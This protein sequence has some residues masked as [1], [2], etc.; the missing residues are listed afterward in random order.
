VVSGLALLFLPQLPVASSVVLL[1]V[2][3][4]WFVSKRSEILSFLRRKT[5]KV[6]VSVG[7]AHVAFAVYLQSVARAEPVVSPTVLVETVLTAPLN[8]IFSIVF[9]FLV[10]IYLFAMILFPIL[11]WEKKRLMLPL[12]VAAVWVLW[13]A[14][15]NYLLWGTYPISEF[16]DYHYLLINNP[17]PAPDYASKFSLP[18]SLMLLS[19]VLEMAYREQRRAGS[20]LNTVE[21]CPE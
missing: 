2:Y 13:G 17:T 1:P 5:G 16:Y 10:Y 12:A 3:V 19:A 7:L 4:E 9:A 21:E 11:A 8:G 14:W 15:S 18:I 20:D 6:A